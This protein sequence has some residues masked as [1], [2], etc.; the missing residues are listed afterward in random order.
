M[1]LNLLQ[2][3]NLAS[4]SLICP[5][6]WRII[7]CFKFKFAVGII[8]A[9]KLLNLIRLARK[10]SSKQIFACKPCPVIG[11]TP[12]IVFLIESITLL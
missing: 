6:L 9:L 1:G 5:S 7:Y 10:M 12:Q 3:L 2:V 11:D 4:L 8:S